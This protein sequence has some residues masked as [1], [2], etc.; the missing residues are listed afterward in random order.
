MTSQ[1]TKTQGLHSL[2]Q[3]EEQLHALQHAQRKAEQSVR[4]SFALMQ[5]SCPTALPLPSLVS[6]AVTSHQRAAHTMLTNTHAQKA[7]LLIASLWSEL[8]IPWFH[9]TVVRFYQQMLERLAALHRR[10]SS[11]QAC[12]TSSSL[13]RAGCLRRLLQQTTTTVTEAEDPDRGVEGGQQQQQGP[14]CEEDGPHCS[15]VSELIHSLAHV[16]KEDMVNE[17]CDSPSRPRH[18]NRMCM[19]E[20]LSLWCRVLPECTEHL[21]SSASASFLY[22]QQ[23]GKTEPNDGALRTT[24]ASDRPLWMVECDDDSSS[25]VNRSH[26]QK[27]HRS[28]LWY[29]GGVGAL[30]SQRLRRHVEQERVNSGWSDTLT[31][32]G[33]LP[34]FPSSSWQPPWETLNRLFHCL[35]ASTLREATEDAAAAAVLRWSR[36]DASVK[37]CQQVGL[38][39]WEAMTRRWEAQ[40][41]VAGRQ[42]GYL[43]THCSAMWCLELVAELRAAM[44]AATSEPSARHLP[45]TEHPPSPLLPPHGKDRT[46]LLSASEARH[47][48]LL[49]LLHHPFYSTPSSH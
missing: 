44:M 15:L 35:A 36:F 14:D 31:L 49:L 26:L 32:S 17:E 25:D 5:S 16:E 47:H 43:P 29:A 27:T 3:V 21:L 7:K 2:D 41:H 8:V 38:F 42:L 18:I 22:F 9:S 6:R 46:P 1:H 30:L 20:A 24:H 13:S 28:L 4:H 19:R 34:S 39:R 48:P 10:V 23:E 11:M 33:A 40:Q 45:L 37:E 12:L